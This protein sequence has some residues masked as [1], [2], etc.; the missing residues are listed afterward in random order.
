MSD[1]KDLNDRHREGQRLH[2]PQKTAKPANEKAKLVPLRKELKAVSLSDGF[3]RIIDNATAGAPAMGMLLGH[4]TLD[5]RMCGLRRGYVAALGARTSFGKT[6]KA[7]QICDLNMKK[8]PVLFISVEDGEAMSLKRLIARRAN[9]N[10]LRLRDNKCEPHEVAAMKRELLKAERL[11]FFLDA[12]GV[13]VEDICVFIR[14][15]AKEHGTALVVFDYLQKA[16]SKKRFSERR[17]EVG[18]IA[19]MLGD[20]IKEVNAAGLL[21]SQLARPDKKNPNVFPGM[22]DLKEAGELE[23][24]VEHVIVGHVE[25]EPTDNPKVRRRIRKLKIYK[26]KDG[27][28]FDEVIEEQF[29]DFTASFVET[30]PLDQGGSGYGD[31]EN[32]PL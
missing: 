26:N 29:N 1:A 28:V 10:A 15:H 30:Y 32:L 23:N 12:S 5:K 16:K 14:Q 9:V 19:Q 22:H 4:T 2:D 13:H 20:T 3:A 31:Q 18:E 11:P 6:S 7:L 25:D 27:P 8:H 17:V 21:L 24:A